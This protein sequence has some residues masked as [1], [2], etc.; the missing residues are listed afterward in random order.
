MS[1]KCPPPVPF[2]NINKDNY[3]FYNSGRWRKISKGYRLKH[4]MCQHCLDEG[5][6]TP[7]NM[8][9]HIT[10]IDKGGDKFNS[11]NLMSLC[12]HHHAVKTGRSK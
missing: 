4:P 11:F 10:A 12:T 8:V 2:A 3:S 1:C 5:V 6:S 9:D 7:A